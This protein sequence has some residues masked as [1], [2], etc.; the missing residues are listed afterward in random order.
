MILSYQLEDFSSVCAVPGQF[1]IDRFE[2]IGRP[3]NMVWPHKHS[4]YE[5]LWLEKGPSMHKIDHHSFELSFDSIFF[6]APGQIHEL[7]QE[8]NLIGYS[9]MFSPEFL[10][11]I[12]G[13]QELF[14][15]LS[16]MEDTYAHPAIT[17]L[18]K[19]MKE[20][21]SC[22]NMLLKEAERSDRSVDVLR[23]LLLVFLFQIKRM[24]DERPVLTYDKHQFIIVKKFKILLEQHY[25]EETRLSF[26]A[27][28]LCIT[29]AHLN[30]VLKTV[31][32]KTGAE[33]IRERLLL[34]SKRM[35]LHG[36]LSVGQIAAE[37]GFTDFSYFS[38]QFKKQEG[39]SPVA[40]RRSKQLLRC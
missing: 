3:K 6:I 16:F 11:L 2:N 8:D 14:S 25:K 27:D 12:E 30:E 19:E 15:G 37:L 7:A 40:F 34:E 33:T 17:L 5:I 29:T 39:L 10:T 9:I 23:H 28:V 26:F 22:L 1:I 21:F 32:G 36:D 13:G 24:I 31:T 38:R 4:F 18:P 35:L 20:L